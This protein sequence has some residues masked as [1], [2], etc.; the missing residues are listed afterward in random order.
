MKTS[1]T[2]GLAYFLMIFAFYFGTITLKN[3]QTATTAGAVASYWFNVK[4]NT[5]RA[6]KRACTTSLGSIAYGSLL[7]AILETLKQVARETSQKSGFAACCAMCL[8]SCLES[9]LEYL[10]RWGF[11][12]VGM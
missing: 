12:Y 4:G 6:L 10:N 5:S 9:I 8:L 3:I 1:S 7:V 11:I 2:D